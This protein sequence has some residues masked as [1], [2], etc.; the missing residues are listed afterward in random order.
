MQTNNSGD[1]IANF[2]YVVDPIRDGGGNPTGWE[3]YVMLGKEIVFEYFEDPSPRPYNGH[4]EM[5]DLEAAF[6]RRLAEVLS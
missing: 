6:A 1:W 5:Y 3:G 2:R 4:F